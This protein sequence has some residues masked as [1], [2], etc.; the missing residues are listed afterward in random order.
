MSIFKHA[1]SRLSAGFFLSL[2]LSVSLLLSWP[3]SAQEEEQEDGQLYVPLSEPL[4]V[5]YGGPGRLKYLRAE[6][7]LRLDQSRDAGVIR[8]HMPLIRHHLVMLFSR[9]GEE[10][11]NTQ[12]GREQLRQTALAET[13]ALLA[14]EEG[15][16]DVVRDLLFR[17]FVVQR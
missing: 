7:S 9:Q 17:N 14:Q 6:V 15:R 13:N 11:I 10:E 16:E 4:V 5:N 8:H 12:S 1:Y 3:A 2:A